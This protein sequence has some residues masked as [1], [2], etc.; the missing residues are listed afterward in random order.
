VAIWADDEKLHDGDSERT[1]S[2]RSSAASRDQQ[3]V[4]D[5]NRRLG[6]FVFTKECL[7][8]SNCTYLLQF[9]LQPRILGFYATLTS[10]D[11]NPNIAFGAQLKFTATGHFSDGTVLVLT[12]QMKWESSDATI[13]VINPTGAR[14][15]A[16]VGT[17]VITATLNGVSGI[18]TLTVH[19]TSLG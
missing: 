6:R 2:L 11:V 18:A 1:L 17:A 14:S 13:A 12:R 19:W 3:S 4:H 8:G 5:S 16:G 9:L 7:Q 15:T 10:V